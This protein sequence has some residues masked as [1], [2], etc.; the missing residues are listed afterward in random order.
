MAVEML[1]FVLKHSWWVAVSAL[2]PR[3]ATA[4]PALGGLCS[5]ACERASICTASLWSEPP[6]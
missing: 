5:V 1:A 4:L 2:P 3:R 6:A